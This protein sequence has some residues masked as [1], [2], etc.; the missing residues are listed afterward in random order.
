VILD[1]DGGPGGSLQPL[2]C[3]NASYLDSHYRPANPPIEL[4]L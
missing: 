3:V 2:R 1:R 4:E